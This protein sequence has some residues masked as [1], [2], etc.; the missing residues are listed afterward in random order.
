ME[1]NDEVELGNYW[2]IFKRSWWMIALAMLFMTALALAFLPGQDT[3]F[4]SNVSVLLRPGDADVGPPGDPVNEDTEIG[5]ATSPLVGTRVLMLL[6]EM[7]AV[8][9]L[10]LD[11]WIENLEVTC[12]DS[13]ASGVNRCDSQILEFSYNGDSADEASEVVRITA[14]EYL[15]FR[16]EREGLLR[17]SQADEVRDRLENLEGQFANELE[18][19]Q[20]AQDEAQGETT[21]DV[22]QS[23]NRLSQ[24]QDE[25]F[26]TQLELGGI[27]EENFEVGNFLGA[28]SNPEA[29]A[30]GIPR[31]FTLIAGILMGF[32]VGALAA[33]LTDRL[34][35][36]I[37]GP[38]ETEL[39][40]GVPVL[41]N[42]PRITEDSP[43]LVAAFGQDSAG[44]EAFRRLAAAVLAPRDGFVVDSIAV[45][46]ATDKDGRTTAAINLAL[47]ISQTGRNVLLVGA[48]RRNDALDRV[49]GIAGRTGLSDFL[50]TAGDLD[51][52]RTAIDNAEKKFDLTILPTGTGVPSPIA[53][54]SIAALLAI[55][56]ERNMIVVFD[57]PPAL[58]NAEGLQLAAI[59]DAVYVVS[60][61]GRTRRS[62]LRNLRIQ[63]ENVQADLAGAVLNRTSRLNLLPTGSADVGSVSVPSGVPGN[64]RTGRPLT[65]DIASVHHFGKQSD[66]NFGVPPQMSVVPVEAADAE[67]IS[68]RPIEPGD[69]G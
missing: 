60:A 13:G 66:S 41:G 10:R 22:I 19:L 34:D 44:A 61:I 50:R 53:N 12:L 29:D 56:Q 47:A 25:L 49:F 63:L 59:V 14:E 35:R 55:A 43:A 3:F 42:I 69:V 18:V 45:T 38:I 7:D 1:T 58:T 15:A 9:S 51:S 11:E 32:V 40:L 31:L 67:V 2:R 36:R 30:T 52:A 4:N 26:E 24:L 8:D 62:E 16:S 65:D 48:D 37:S 23:G 28:P 17:T 6:P 54:N 46:G 33:V 39:D 68:E 21:L 27:Q 5:I 20:N 57:A 64:N